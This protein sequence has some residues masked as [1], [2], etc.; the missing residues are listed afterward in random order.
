[1]VHPT[2]VEPVTFAFGGQ[3]SIQL[4]YGCVRLR[5]AHSSGVGNVC[6]SLHRSKL[7]SNPGVPG[8]AAGFPRA[9]GGPIRREF[10]VHSRIRRFLALSRRFRVIAVMRAVAGRRALQFVGAENRERAGQPR[11]PPQLDHD[12][13]A[14]LMLRLGKLPRTLLAA[15]ENG[16]SCSRKIGRE[17]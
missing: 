4:S 2:G 7:S 10:A 11:R 8:G 5:L 9:A 14:S 1:M 3:R 12:G 17:K 6:S 15:R 13:R 16:V